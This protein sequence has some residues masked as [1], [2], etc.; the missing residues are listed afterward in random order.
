MA[1]RLV[2]A[3]DPTKALIRAIAMD[4]GKEAVHHVKT[5]YPAAIK[6]CPST[7][8]LSLR[9]CIHN[10]IIAAIEVT[11]EGEIIARIADRKKR[12]RKGYYKKIVLD[13]LKKGEIIP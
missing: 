2:I 11:D 8:P 1:K 7:F 4:I 12:R 3:G 5:M 9:N 10:E 6:A 13:A